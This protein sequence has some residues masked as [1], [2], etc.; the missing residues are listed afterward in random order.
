MKNGIGDRVMA[1]ALLAICRLPISMMKY[2]LRRC[3]SPRL[4]TSDTLIAQITMLLVLMV[5][6]KGIAGVPRASLV[7]VAAV[8]P[9]FGSLEAGLLLILGIDHFDMGRTV[10][11]V[12][13]NAITTA[14]VARKAPS[15]RWTRRWPSVKSRCRWKVKPKR[16]AQN[17]PGVV[18]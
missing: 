12:L 10:T 13:G 14:V 2:H 17:L 9:M 4:L 15:T 18:V 1:E 7:V 11:N 6:S 8:L 3:S 16:R 5:S